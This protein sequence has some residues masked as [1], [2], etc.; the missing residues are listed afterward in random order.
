MKTSIENH[1]PEIIK[2]NLNILDRYGTYILYMPVKLANQENVASTIND[3]NLINLIFKREGKKNLFDKYIYLSFETS[4][5][6]AGK[7]QKR[8]GW[9]IDGFLSDDINYL[10]YSNT[11]TIFN[12][13]KFELDNCHSLSIQ[14]ME[15]QAKEENNIIYPDK[16]LLRLDNNVV[17]KAS[18][19]EISGVRTFVK[20]SISSHKYNLNGNT[21]NPYLCYNWKMH[22]RNLVRNHPIY[23]ENDFVPEGIDLNK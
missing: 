13:G 20:L 23:K 19:P 3:S 7:S 15:E 1:L 16:T 5:V 8:P 14:Q 12:K 11:P 21:K 6:Q 2:T 18:I 17:H 10:W 22:D 9:H 4:Y